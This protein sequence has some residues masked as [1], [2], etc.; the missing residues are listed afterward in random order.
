MNKWLIMLGIVA[1]GVGAVGAIVGIFWLISRRYRDEYVLDGDGGR[2]PD[3]TPIE[4]AGLDSGRDSSGT[5]Y[6][7]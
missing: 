2:V 5:G 1:I 3:A 6:H 4:S 7:M